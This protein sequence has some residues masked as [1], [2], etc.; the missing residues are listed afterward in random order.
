MSFRSGR[1][2]RGHAGAAA[3]ALAS[4]G[5]MLSVLHRRRPWLA[6]LA[7]VSATVLVWRAAEAL[8]SPWNP[9]VALWPIVALVVLFAERGKS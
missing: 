1:Q 9:H 6:L 4:L 5:T 8:A 7:A 3:L 2:L